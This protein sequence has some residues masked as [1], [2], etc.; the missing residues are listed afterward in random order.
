MTNARR[1]ADIQTVTL[2]GQ[3]FSVVGDGN[4]QKI[5]VGYM[6][7]RLAPFSGVKKIM[8]ALQADL[9]AHGDPESDEV[10]ESFDAWLTE[11]DPDSKMDVYQ[12]AR[13]YERRGKASA[14]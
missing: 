1:G 13:A 6:A 5:C 9:V 4:P 11:T 2:G 7:A 12:V 3:Q 10:R 14:P 8:A